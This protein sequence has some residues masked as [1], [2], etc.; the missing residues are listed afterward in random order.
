MPPGRTAFLLILLLRKILPV[1]ASFALR[2]MIAQAMLS[3]IHAE[4]D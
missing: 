2:F 1:S 3:N 4:F